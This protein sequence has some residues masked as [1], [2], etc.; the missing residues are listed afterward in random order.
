MS[1]G[2]GL[3][4]A[5]VAG[6]LPASRQQRISLGI[7]SSYRVRKGFICHIYSLKVSYRRHGWR[8][9]REEILV[10]LYSKNWQTR[11][12][13]RLFLRLRR[14]CFLLLSGSSLE[15]ISDNVS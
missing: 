12:E 1:A 15:V 10:F 11:G 4:R 13:V 5:D 6:L 7:R 14:P 3:S 8:F 2:T 9:T